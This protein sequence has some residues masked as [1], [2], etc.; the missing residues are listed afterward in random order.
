[1]LQKLKKLR[2][3]WRKMPKRKDKKKWKNFGKALKS[4]QPKKIS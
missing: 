2:E 1:M 3:L 4:L